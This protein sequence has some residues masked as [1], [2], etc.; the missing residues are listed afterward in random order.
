MNCRGSAHRCGESAAQV[1]QG[2]RRLQGKDSEGRRVAD[3]V[4][5]AGCLEDFR[6]AGVHLRRAVEYGSVLFRRLIA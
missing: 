4:N 2:Y 1:K 6:R 3:P 5:P